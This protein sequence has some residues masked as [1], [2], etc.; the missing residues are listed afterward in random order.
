M[1][2]LTNLKFKLYLVYNDYETSYTTYINHARWHWCLR[3]DGLRVG[4]NRSAR[5]KPTNLIWWPHD[6]LTY[7]RRVSN[8]GRSGERR[9]RYH[10]ASQ[11]ASCHIVSKELWRNYSNLNIIL[12]RNPFW[13]MIPHMWDYIR[14]WASV[15][16]SQSPW[17][18]TIADYGTCEYETDDA[19]WR[20][21]NYTMQLSLCNFKIWK[22][23]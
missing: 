22:V 5:R 6:H 14:A 17:L 10:C 20:W 11:T 15:V 1:Y 9:V 18:Q 8:P 16:F 4:G 12:G 7:R 13:T 21:K 19:K 3:S 2:S 23:V